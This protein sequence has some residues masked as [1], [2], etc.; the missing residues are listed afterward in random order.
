MIVCE[1]LLQLL[2]LLLCVFVCVF[3]VW[4]GRGQLTGVS[5]PRDKT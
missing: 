4:L 3:C 2:L 5:S 1:I